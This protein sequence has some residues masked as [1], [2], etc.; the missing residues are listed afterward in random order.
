MF[1][2]VWSTMINHWMVWGSLFGRRHAQNRWIP[3]HPIC[4]NDQRK[5]HG[6]RSTRDF[7]PVLEASHIFPYV[8][9]CLLQNWLMSHIFRIVPPDFPYSPRAFPTFFSPFQAWPGTWILRLPSSRSCGSCCRSRASTSNWWRLEVA[10]G[11]SLGES[12]I[13][14]GLYG[15]SN[16]HYWMI[17][18]YNY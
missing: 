8:P 17:W 13:S 2:S 16:R 12:M 4:S 5:H 15:T 6:W 10:P 7:R 18:G 1:W 9:L 14:T 11:D 3:L